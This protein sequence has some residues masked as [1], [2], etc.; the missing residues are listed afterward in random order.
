V[1]QLEIGSNVGLLQVPAPPNPKAPLGPHPDD[2]RLDPLWEK[3]S[4]LGMPISFHTG[5][6][7]RAPSMSSL[8]RTVETKERIPHVRLR[9]LTDVRI[10]LPILL[11]SVAVALAA[12]VAFGLFAYSQVVEAGNR[13]DRAVGHTPGSRHRT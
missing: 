10:N 4:Q 3:A 11:F 6:S 8:W 2:P 9:F 7:A 5:F 1:W 13:P 12:G